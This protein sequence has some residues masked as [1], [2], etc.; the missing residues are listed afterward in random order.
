MAKG[1]RLKC[2]KIVASLHQIDVLTTNGKTLVK[3]IKE[4][5]NVE[6]SC[7]RW[8]KIYGDIKVNT[9]QS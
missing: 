6:Q 2:E 9:A 3:A 5:G 8:R 1:R 4:G 7:Y